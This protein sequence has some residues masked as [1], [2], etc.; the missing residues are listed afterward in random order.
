MNKKLIGKN[1]VGETVIVEC[2]DRSAVMK[3]QHAYGKVG[4]ALESLDKATKDE[5][6]RL[7]NRPDDKPKYRF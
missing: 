2:E 7:V 6:D 4:I 1:I 5:A 3:A